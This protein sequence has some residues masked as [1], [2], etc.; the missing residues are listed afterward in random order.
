MQDSLIVSSFLKKT[1]THKQG[2]IGAEHTRIHIYTHTHSL[3]L[4]LSLSLSVCVCVFRRCRLIGLDL[5]AP[6][7]RLTLLRNHSATLLHICQATPFARKQAS[8][9]YMNIS[10]WAQVLLC[11][12]L[13]VQMDPE[14]FKLKFM[15]CECM[16]YQSLPF[17]NHCYAGYMCRRR[18]Y[19]APLIECKFNARSCEQS[20]SYIGSSSSVVWKNYRFW[21]CNIHTSCAVCLVCQG[22]QLQ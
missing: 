13:S 19:E 12:S 18:S 8:E 10:A 6:L 4:S 14:Y 21:N 3:S 20:W 16:M 5:R 11:S 1:H 9:R 22:H 2:K 7:H 17:A 15:W